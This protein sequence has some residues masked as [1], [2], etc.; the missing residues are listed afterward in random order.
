LKGKESAVLVTSPG[1]IARPPR[2]PDH[3]GYNFAS[4]YL[5]SH[6]YLTALFKDSS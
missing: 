6:F 3:F 2:Q 1:V 5:P 4:L